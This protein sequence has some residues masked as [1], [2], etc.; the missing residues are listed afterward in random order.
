MSKGVQLQESLLVSE[1]L[2]V[3][4]DSRIQCWCTFTN[5]TH[6]GSGEASLAR[7]PGPV[8]TQTVLTQDQL[9][10]SCGVLGRSIPVS[11]TTQEI[12]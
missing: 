1:G 6:M 2:R 11:T 10:P 3:L 8:K 4:S 7:S 5:R 9:W 12:A